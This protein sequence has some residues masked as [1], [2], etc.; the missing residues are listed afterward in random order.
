ML[1][2]HIAVWGPS[3]SGKTTLAA[4]LAARCGLPHVE[5]DAL[6]WKPDW[7]EPPLEEFRAA[8]ETALAAHPDGWVMDGNYAR[9]QDLVLPRADTLVWLQPPLW[10]VL[11]QVVR[12]TVGRCRSGEPLW[13]SNRETWRK[14]FLSRES[15]IWYILRNWWRYPRRRRQLLATVPH[16]ARVIVLRSPR[17]VRRLFRGLTAPPPAGG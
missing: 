17:D 16:H 8:I 10:R 5:M 2:R 6:F 3:A 4:S 15:L 9:V 14:A 12:R 13:G 7:V 1:G 11:G